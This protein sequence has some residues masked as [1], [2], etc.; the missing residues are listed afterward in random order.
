MLVFDH[1]PIQIVLFLSVVLAVALWVWRVIGRRRKL[2]RLPLRAVAVLLALASSLLL[3]VD[4][5]TELTTATEASSPLYSPDHK[6]AVVVR[7]WD[8]GALGGGTYLDMYSYGGLFEEH[9]AGGDWKIIQA[10]DIR[11]T[12][13]SDLILGYSPEY[14][15]KPSCESSVDVR[16]TC[17]PLP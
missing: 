11:W 13:N 10:Q 8:F 3:L 9:I 12:S 1:R 4:G 2:L 16:V 7:D 14:G 15:S 17:V 6:R 5:C